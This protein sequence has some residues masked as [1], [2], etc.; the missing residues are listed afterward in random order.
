MNSERNVEFH[1][2]VPVLTTGWNG[3][4]LEYKTGTARL[5]IDN[6]V[7]PNKLKVGKESWRA[8]LHIPVF[9]FDTLC[10]L[11]RSRVQLLSGMNVFAKVSVDTEFYKWRAG[12]TIPPLLSS[13][14]PFKRPDVGHMIRTLV[15]R[16]VLSSDYADAA[17]ARHVSDQ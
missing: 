2:P 10:N 11:Q 1:L 14:E 15:T 3:P 4:D 13:S 7:F 9:A 12:W 6:F 8:P 5:D 16:S 17:E